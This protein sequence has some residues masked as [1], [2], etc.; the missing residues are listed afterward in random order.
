MDWEFVKELALIV[1]SS[2]VS[3]LI[4]LVIAIWKWKSKIDTRSK[5]NS[6]RIDA[7][8]KR[9]DDGE[10]AFKTCIKETEKRLIDRIEEV[11][12]EGKEEHEKVDKK[13]DNIDSKMDTLI[14]EFR[15][16]K[17]EIKGRFSVQD[18][19]NKDNK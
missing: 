15:E 17:G 13:V 16:F 18:S 1:F 4:T 9:V 3:A 12:S 11:R 6:T 5:A 14:G 2:V 7:L 8:E 10:S 19:I